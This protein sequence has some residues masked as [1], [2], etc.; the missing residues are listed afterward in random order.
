[1]NAALHTEAVKFLRS[2]APVATAAAFPL[3]VLLAAL[4]VSASG[5]TLGGKSEALGI[6]P[7]WPGFHTALMQVNAAGGFLLFGILVTWTFGREFSDRA[8]LDLLALPT[9]R[10]AIVLA[11]FTITATWL[12]LLGVLQT[13][14]W[15][16]TGTLLDLPGPLAAHA[17]LDLFVLLILNIALT[18]PVGLAA[19]AGRGYLPG[20]AATVALLVS[21]VAAATLGG[22]GWFPWAVPATIGGLTGAPSA[23]VGGPAIAAATAAAGVAATVLWWRRSD[24]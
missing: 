14:G 21:G 12:L 7:D 16:A 3:P 13:A 2:R 20:V 23:T 4:F 1:M 8:V 10:T 17:Y 9:S 11:K 19:S 5:T 15:L 18:L 22:A 6:T 24:H